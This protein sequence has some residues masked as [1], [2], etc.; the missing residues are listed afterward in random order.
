MCAHM[1]N[2]WLLDDN[3]QDLVPPLCWVLGTV[4]KSSVLTR[5][6]MELAL[7]PWSVP[8]SGG[9]TGRAQEFYFIQEA[10][11]SAG[12]DCCSVSV[13][14][15]LLSRKEHL[16][17]SHI[18][19]R[20]HA[21]LRTKTNPRAA[22]CTPLVPPLVLPS[23]VLPSQ[24]QPASARPSQAQVLQTG[25]EGAITTKE[26]WQIRSH[27]LSPLQSPQTQDRK[28]VGLPQ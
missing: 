19:S 7:D 8:Q 26:V 15:G 11:P 22:P 21:F 4:S 24:A 27:A 9:S 10:A 23:L 12:G 13:L 6:G 14:S 16:P 20:V 28:S 3:V 17:S 2:M 18:F 25:S 5:W 1:T